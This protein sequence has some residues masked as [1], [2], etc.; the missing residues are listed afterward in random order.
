VWALFADAELFPRIVRALA[1]PFRAAGVTRVAGVEARGFLLGGAVA[2]ELGAGFAAIRKES[3]LYPGEKAQARAA[4]GYRGVAHELRLQRAA[5]RPGDRVLVVD[6]WAEAGSQAR[7]A[8]AL[9]GECGGEYAGLA[10]V[11]DQL[12]EDVRSELEPVH[13]L[14]GAELLGPSG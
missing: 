13:A 2:V 4:V 9:V 12:P 11:V 7:A 8:R 5:V 14:V 1:E 3:G 6:D 10:I